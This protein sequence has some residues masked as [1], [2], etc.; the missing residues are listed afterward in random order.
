M[1]PGELTLSVSVSVDN[2]VTPDYDSFA[3]QVLATL[4]TSATA[5]SGG[6]AFTITLTM[7]SG[8]PEAGL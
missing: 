2:D 5:E 4:A 8:H 6:G 1:R 3:W 7:E